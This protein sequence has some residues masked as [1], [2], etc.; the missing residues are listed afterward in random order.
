VVKDFSE[1]FR[2]RL[3][4]VITVGVVIGIPVFYFLLPSEAE[5]TLVIGIDSPGLE[6]LFNSLGNTSGAL[7]VST[8]DGTEGLKAA[9]GDGSISAGISLPGDFV[10]TLLKGGKPEIG[11][12]FSSS[13]PKEARE[14]IQ[15]LLEE[16]SFA[17][18]GRK[19][20]AK[21]RIEVLGEDLAGKQLPF[22]DQAKPMWI[23]LVLIVEFFSLSF[24]M[25]EE[26]QTG[27]IHAILVTPTTTGQVFA[28]KTIVGTTLASVEGFLVLMLMGESASS[29]G[30][31]VPNLLLGAL[32][33]T[34]FAFL[35]ASM[36]KDVMSSFSWIMLIYVVLLI[37]PMSVAFPSI[38]SPAVK[39]LPSYYVA[40][41]FN[42][43]LNYG[44]GLGDIWP[45]LVVLAVFDVVILFAG[46]WALRRRYR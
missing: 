18:A 15:V 27:A 1:M 12:I 39:I 4:L 8:Y 5:E 10:Q 33:S 43:V 7:K 25:V 28:A 46:T 14:S 37:P 24:L 30:A 41:A 13:T 20:P 11:L 42:Q 9:V 17:I 26:T 6:D 2:N 35:V 40:D 32:L 31:L 36:S 45:G 38:S 16:L 29:L 34:G 23:T 19:L 3:T 21:L 44:R 22:R